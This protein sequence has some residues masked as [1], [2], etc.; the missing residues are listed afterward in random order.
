[1][2]IRI[3]IRIRI[4]NTGRYDTYCTV[5]NSD[6]LF[7]TDGYRYGTVPGELDMAIRRSLQGELDKRVA[8]GEARDDGLKQRNLIIILISRKKL[9]G[10]KGFSIY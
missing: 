9:F 8:G 10:S 5:L 2:W 1:M 4:R 6:S 3:R 7:L